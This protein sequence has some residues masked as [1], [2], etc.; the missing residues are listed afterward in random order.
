VNTYSNT[1]PNN[2]MQ[3]SARQRQTKPGGSDGLKLDIPQYSLGATWYIPGFYVPA[4]L[5]THVMIFVLL[6]RKKK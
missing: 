6:V 4:L 1:P 3:R 5:N 2:G